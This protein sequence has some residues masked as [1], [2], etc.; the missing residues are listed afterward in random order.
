M[1]DPDRHVSALELDELVLGSLEP[2]AEAH[3]RAHLASCARCRG[4]EAASSAL[5]E[6]FDRT[7]LARTLPD[8]AH[9][10]RSW[11]L[12]LA[13][14]AL[15]AVVVGFLLIRRPARMDEPELGIKGDATWQVFAN[16]D[17]KTFAV[18][19]GTKLA[20]G[21]R[22]RFVVTPNGATHLLIGSV[23]GA[24][25][26]SIYYPYDGDASGPV[27][28]ARIELP[29]SIVLDHAR[30]PERLQAIFSTAPVS[31]T[32]VKQQLRAIGARGPETIRSKRPLDV[33]A[34]TQLSIVFEKVTP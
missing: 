30:G 6:H 26:V 7:V 3:V 2:A 18:H 31:A 22:I 19:D 21:D 25:E 29:G 13:A 12:G 23:D 24:G 11:W 10:R 27:S 34:S 17:D 5:R 4:D 32:I 33:T 9:A 8:R 16:R 28:G 14:P 1:S 20:A 15:A